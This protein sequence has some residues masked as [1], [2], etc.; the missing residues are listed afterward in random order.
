[1]LWFDMVYQEICDLLIKNLI[2][3]DGLLLFVVVFV[4]INFVLL[5][6]VFVGNLFIVFVLKKCC[7][8]YLLLKVFLF[9]FVLIDF[10]VGLF[11]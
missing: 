4:F 2:I 10:G 1:M 9:S 3:E 6:V 11:F 7:I 5:L 8:I